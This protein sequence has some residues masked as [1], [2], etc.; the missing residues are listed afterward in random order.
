MFA[1]FFYDF[2]ITTFLFLAL[3]I[4]I[5]SFIDAIAGGGGLIS[6]PAYI[7]SGLPIHI[8]L[9]CNKM[10][11]TFSTIGSSLKYIKSKKVNFNSL[12]YPLISSF[13]GACLGVYI[14][15]QLTSEFLGPIIIILLLTVIV[16]TFFNK[17]MGLSSN[18]KGANIKNTFYGTLWAFMI[19]FYIGFFGPGGGSFL[20]FAFIKIYRF[21]FIQAS[22]NAKLI[23]LVANFASLSVFIFLG[24]IDYLY[25]I[26]LS[27]V[28]FLGAQCGAK[29]AIKKG[30][31]FI[32]PIFLITASLTTLK[33]IFELFFN[34]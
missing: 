21:D 29:Y 33:M 28:A 23:N 14:L 13:I 27:L 24:K 31:K 32:R 4:F 17:N 34:L 3:A 18:F 10:S 11:G 16:Y 30:A 7:S 19:S 15:N 2:N 6:V 20:I 8:A 1:N 12:K 5:G 26:P 25:S 22:G 9:G